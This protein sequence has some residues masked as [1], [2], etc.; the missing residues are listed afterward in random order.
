M[1]LWRV[2][3]LRLWR[4][5]RWLALLAPFVAFGFGGP[6][7]AKYLPQILGTSIASGGIR[8]TAPPPVPADG[9]EEFIHNGMGLGVLVAIVVAAA[10]VSVDAHPALGAF[11][12]TRVR[13]SHQLVIPRY[14]VVAVASAAALVAGTGAAWYETTVLLGGLP[15][16]PMV[17]GTAL[18]LLY[19]VFVLALVSAA[20][21]V[22][23]TPLMSAAVALGALFAL[24]LV[25]IVHGAGSW[26]PTSLAAG[27]TTV[28]KT[29]HYR[30]FLDSAIIA[31]AATGA[32]L[33]FAIA[34]I[35]RREL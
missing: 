19:L 2:E 8:I 24:Q 12:R 16:S 14:C 31:A 7:L 20:A 11:Y 22:V 6:I 15:T 9:I 18:E 27:L 4:T 10:A 26:L 13:H 29:R 1:R 33:V 30:S 28:V 3:W 25:G 32:L 21:S 34:R 35:G 17:V 5:R 23:R